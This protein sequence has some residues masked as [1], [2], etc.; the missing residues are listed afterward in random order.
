MPPDLGRY[1]SQPAG[2]RSQMKTLNVGRMNLRTDDRAQFVEAK[3][4]EIL[5][6]GFD[7]HSGSVMAK[8]YSVAWAPEPRVK[9]P[10]AWGLPR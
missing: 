4:D 3:G 2:W 1:G 9:R 6:E 8:S 5:V 7:S 10:R